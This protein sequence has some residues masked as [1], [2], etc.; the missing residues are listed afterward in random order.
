LTG[1]AFGSGLDNN[2]EDA[3]RFLVDNFDEGDEVFVFGFSRGAYTARSLVG[4]I[5]KCGLLEKINAERF[6]DAYALYRDKTH[7]E[8]VVPRRF[9]MTYSREIL[10]RF[11]GVWDTVGAMGI[12]VQGLRR[13]T[14]RRYEFHDLEL[15]KIVLNAYHAVAIDERREIFRPTLWE[16]TPKPGQQLEQIWFAG[17]HSDVGGG[18]PSSGLSDLALQWLMRKAEGCGLAF[19]SRYVQEFIRPA[20]LGPL[21][22]SMR[23]LY[24]LTVA[25]IREIGSP[26][27]TS[28]AVFAGALQ[29]Y[30]DDRWYRPKNLVAY[31]KRADH[32]VVN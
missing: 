5:R 29:R 2:I 28:Q 15:S 9:R 23:G 20:P 22:D 12:P 31:L 4:L 8:D 21:H 10:V 27:Q 18:S 1:G 14:R 30:N 24:R 17:S 25:K 32:R 16:H 13:L 6:D 26:K 7:P 19:S 11:I 3:Y